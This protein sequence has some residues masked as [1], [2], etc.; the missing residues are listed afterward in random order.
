[1]VAKLY[2][3]QLVEET[4][5]ERIWYRSDDL[6]VTGYLA[7]PV[8]VH[9]TTP[10]LIWNRGGEGKRGA[11]DDLTAY[12]I[13]ASTARWGIT[14]LATHYRGNL[15]SEGEED[16]GGDDVHD[17][18]NLIGLARALDWCDCSRIAVE[19]ASRGGMTT[20]RLLT[21]YPHF[22]CAIVHAGI[23]DLFALR[24]SNPQFVEVTDR[25]FGHL[26]DAALMQELTRRSVTR[27]V[28][29]LPETT[30]IFLLHGTADKTVPV[31]QS[32]L[33]FDALQARSHP[34]ELILLPDAGHVALKDGSYQPIDQYRRRWLEKYL[35][36]Y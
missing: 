9:S 31:E 33:I 19:G 21:L 4:T 28:S 12:L 30:P 8:N 5:V 35:Q 24:R 27:F 29:L 18:Y 25:R 14:V 3:T 13:L 26:G 15:G 10:V 1:M 7:R 20:Y 23:S 34:S 6:L 22:R 2:D 16:W 36:L 17:A 11:L 32:Q